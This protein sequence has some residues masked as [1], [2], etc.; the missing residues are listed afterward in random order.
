VL[1]RLGDILSSVSV[2]LCAGIVLLG[3]I[4][5]NR[6]IG[7]EWGMS[8]DDRRTVGVEYVGASRGGLWVGRVTVVHPR[9]LRQHR[10]TTYTDKSSLWHRMGFRLYAWDDLAPAAVGTV[11]IRELELP[12]WMFAVASALFPSIL[13]YRRRRAA[14]RRTVGHCTN[15]GYDLRASPERCPECGAAAAAR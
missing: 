6:D 1:R 3:V 8:K 15:C 2:V 14:Q 9:T 7:F 5:W 4:S 13:L 12:L 10:P 11:G